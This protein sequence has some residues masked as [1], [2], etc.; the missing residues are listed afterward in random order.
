MQQPKKD[1]CGAALTH[2]GRGL[3]RRL[4]TQGVQTAQQ[5]EK[6]PCGPTPTHMLLGHTAALGAPQCIALGPFRT[7]AASPH[8]DYGNARVARSRHTLGALSSGVLLAQLLVLKATSCDRDSLHRRPMPLPVAKAS[9][10]PPCAST[11]PRPRSS[12]HCTVYRQDLQA[13]TTYTGTEEENLRL[14][15]KKSPKPEKNPHNHIH[16]LSRVL[17]KRK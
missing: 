15:S 6:D 12:A 16:K 10:S 14:R 11:K 17:S 3:S 8:L 13:H 2:C 5:P 4:R 1:L 7:S 9:L